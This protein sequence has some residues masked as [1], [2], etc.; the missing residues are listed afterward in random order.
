MLRFQ[1]D[2]NF[3]HFCLLSDGLIVASCIIPV[4]NNGGQAKAIELARSLLPTVSEIEQGQKELRERVEIY[5]SAIKKA[6]KFK[7]ILSLPSREELK[8]EKIAKEISN[9]PII[10]GKEKMPQISFD[11]EARS[12]F[13]ASN[14]AYNKEYEGKVKALIEK[15][16]KNSEVVQVWGEKTEEMEFDKDTENR[17]EEI[18]PDLPKEIKIAEITRNHG[19]PEFKDYFLLYEGKEKEWVFAYTSPKDKT[20]YLSKP[21]LSKLLTLSYQRKIPRAPSFFKMLIQDEALQADSQYPPL[22]L[23]KNDQAFI[24]YLRALLLKERVVHSQDKV[25]VK[26]YFA[27]RYVFYIA[28]RLVE[29]RKGSIRKYEK[30]EVIIKGGRPFVRK[31]HLYLILDGE[32]EIKFDGKSIL[33]KEGDLFRTVAFLRGVERMGNA[34]VTA[35]KKLT[36]A[37]VNKRQF[38]EKLPGDFHRLV[39]RIAKE[40]DYEYSLDAERTD[41]LRRDWVDGIKN[42]IE[43][44]KSLEEVIEKL[45]RL[46]WKEPIENVRQYLNR[47]REYAQKRDVY[48][49]IKHSQQ[50]NED[51]RMIW[52]V[53]PGRGKKGELGVK[54]ANDIGYCINSNAVIP[55]WQEILRILLAEENLL[56]HGKGVWVY[57]NYKSVLIL[58]K[59]RKSLEHELER[60][61]KKLIK[62][63]D[64]FLKGKS[65]L[66]KLKHHFGLNAKFNA[67]IDKGIN[68]KFVITYGVSE[69]FR[70]RE[71]KTLRLASQAQKAAYMAR[72]GDAGGLFFNQTE[73]QK[74]MEEA[75]RL[76]QD[77]EGVKIGGIEVLTTISNNSYEY[78]IVN[79][80]M[81]DFIEKAMKEGVEPKVEIDIDKAVKEGLSLGVFK[82]QSAKAL[83]E[84]FH[85]F[86]VIRYLELV[87]INDFLCEWSACLDLAKEKTEEIEQL[88]GKLERMEQGL[89]ELESSKE[90]F[91]TAHL[92]KITELADEA[93]RVLSGDIKI[94][95]L[96]SSWDFYRKIVD[97]ARRSKLTFIGTDVKGLGAK[98]RNA[99]E[100]L[101]QDVEANRMSWDEVI[102]VEIP[103]LI[104]EFLY[105][106]R[107]KVF[108]LCKERG[109]PD[110]FLL[111]LVGGDEFGLAVP[112][113]Y[114]DKEFLLRIREILGAR[115]AIS[116]STLYEERKEDQ[117]IP[118]IPVCLA[119]VDISEVGQVFA[120]EQES[121]K[122]EA[123]VV[124][125]SLKGWV[126]LETAGSSSELL[127]VLKSI[128]DESPAIDVG[129]LAGSPLAAPH[130]HLHITTM[131]PVLEEAEDR[132]LQW[133]DIEEYL[134]F[135]GLELDLTTGEACI[136]GEIKDSVG[137]EG[138]DGIIFK[139]IMERAVERLNSLEDEISGNKAKISAWEKLLG[140]KVDFVSHL[141]DEIFLGDDN[142]QASISIIAASLKGGLPLPALSARYAYVDGADQLQIKLIL[143]VELVKKAI[144]DYKRLSIKIKK[145]EAEIE[146]LQEELRKL[147]A[148]QKGKGFKYHG[149]LLDRERKTAIRERENRVSS[150]RNS[151]ESHILRQKAIVEMFF[152]RIFHELGEKNKKPQ[153]D[154]E[155]KRYEKA[156]EKERNQ[157]KYD[158]ILYKLGHPHKDIE[159]YLKW[160]DSHPGK[161][162]Y[163]FAFLESLGRILEAKK[164]HSRNIA[165]KIDSLIDLY[166]KD[167]F[168]TQD[169]FAQS[170]IAAMGMKKELHLLKKGIKPE[171]LKIIMELFEKKPEL[172]NRLKDEINTPKFKEKLSPA[173]LE[174]LNLALGSYPTMSSNQLQKLVGQSKRIFLALL[175]K[176]LDL[177]LEGLGELKEA[178]KGRVRVIYIPGHS[179]KEDFE[180]IKELLEEERRL[181]E[182]KK[183][184]FIAVIETTGLAIESIIKAY[185][186]LKKMDFN[187]KRYEEIFIKRFK[188]ADRIHKGLYRSFE[189]G[190][191]HYG[192]DISESGHFGF[193]DELFTYLAENKIKTIPEDAGYQ[194]WL[195]S[196]G[197]ENL[198]GLLLQ[199]F[200]QADLAFKEQ[201]P[202]AYHKLLRAYVDLRVISNTSRDA[203]IANQIENLMVKYPGVHIVIVLG[204]GHLKMH[205]RLRGAFYEIEHEMP[206]FELSDLSP[207]DEV[208]IREIINK[209]LDKKEERG[210]LFRVFPAH[211]FY[212]KISEVE[213]E[214]YLAIKIARKIA[215]R[216]E[217]KEIC[218]LLKKIRQERE[219]FYRWMIE[220]GRIKEEE[221]HYF[222]PQLSKKEKGIKVEQNKKVS[223]SIKAKL[224]PGAEDAIGL[225]IDVDKVRNWRKY[226]G[227]KPD[228]EEL[229]KLPGIIGQL[230][231]ALEILKEKKALLAP[232]KEENTDKVSHKTEKIS[233]HGDE[234]GRVKSSSAISAPGLFSFLLV[235]D[236]S[237]AVDILRKWLELDI[238]NV[239][240]T[241]AGSGEEALKKFSEREGYDEEGK[242]IARKLSVL[243]IDKLDINEI[244]SQAKKLLSIS[245]PIRNQAIADKYN[246]IERLISEIVDGCCPKKQKGI[247]GKLCD[248]LAEDLCSLSHNRIDYRITLGNVLPYLNPQREPRDIGYFQQILERKSFEVKRSEIC[249]FLNDELLIRINSDSKEKWTTLLWILNMPSVMRMLR[250]RRIIPD[251]DKLQDSYEVLLRCA[252]EYDKR[253]EVKFMTY[254]L[255]SIKHNII[256]PGLFEQECMEIE[257][258][259][260]EESLGLARVLPAHEEEGYEIKKTVNE[261]L[262]QWWQK[263]KPGVRIILGRENISCFEI[264]T[265]KEVFKEINHLRGRD[266]R[267]IWNKI[268]RE[269]PSLG[270]YYASR[271]DF[272]E[273]LYF[274]FIAFSVLREDKTFV[275]IGDKLDISR[276]MTRNYFS[277][278]SLLIESKLRGIKPYVIVEMREKLKKAT[279]TL[280]IRPSWEAY[281]FEE[282]N[283]KSLLLQRYKEA[284]KRLIEGGEAIFPQ[285]KLRI[286]VYKQGAW[287]KEVRN[288]F[289]KIKSIYL[290]LPYCTYFMRFIGA[291]NTNGKKAIIAEFRPQG[292]RYPEYKLE[293]KIIWLSGNGGKF[294]RGGSIS[295]DGN[296]GGGVFYVNGRKDRPVEFKLA[297][298]GSPA[299]THQEVSTQ[300]I[301]AHTV[302]SSFVGDVS[303]PAASSPING[304][305]V[306]T[307]NPEKYR[308]EILKKQ[309]KRIFNAAVSIKGAAVTLEAMDNP[310]QTYYFGRRPSRMKGIT[311]V[312]EI[313]ENKIG[314]NL[315]IESS[316]RDKGYGR[317][318][319]AELRRRYPGKIIRLYTFCDDGSQI[320]AARMLEQK[321]IDEI[322]VRGDNYFCAYVDVP[323]IHPPVYIC[324][325]TIISTGVSIAEGVWISPNTIDSF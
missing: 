76:R 105:E 288:I 163:Y 187:S 319:A 55:K 264:K 101:V 116:T 291:V 178:K 69:C 181:A 38:D 22:S 236:N 261:L 34:T 292:R 91:N 254:Y 63:M 188:R 35:K 201:E 256:F 73:Y 237:D 31:K 162:G 137:K 104:E 207:E 278:I 56:G 152:E 11:L 65:C 154:T 308:H 252:S 13:L 95:Q 170:N 316:F 160:T 67:L 215:D 192:L 1:V 284:V 126:N 195:E 249:N 7:Y 8:Q 227:N 28:S 53:V 107:K 317:K 245:S 297:Q 50:D 233:R 58:V 263:V 20:I 303:S 134:E 17:L 298:S 21:A 127:E 218:D 43:E 193:L 33:L 109:I 197:A 305:D 81:I 210:I 78:K 99:L 176:Y 156:W 150:L 275:Q 219:S 70:Q 269:Y 110:E 276:Q 196:Y 149:E 165:Q 289:D 30:G 115:V 260:S 255:A 125:N 138:K 274:L 140:L 19:P 155:G 311:E 48:G 89:D 120:K 231:K 307:F 323:W 322:E 132:T 60:V 241:T 40:R 281:L 108:D 37:T 242:N 51:C 117:L 240:I 54:N 75:G 313:L 42:Q 10:L 175:W 82:K 94:P 39:Y 171:E 16:K 139:E 279:E 271:K 185:P 96:N 124:E 304:V 177:P 200:T 186:E 111:F 300:R 71:E 310:L 27:R 212:S 2:S 199:S 86:R 121:S 226:H 145:E 5:Y 26:H 88:L 136:K 251:E 184:K 46:R 18:F 166:L 41:Y 280:Q 97:L 129:G 247:I 174:T 102:N 204:L 216:L 12:S 320:F 306:C 25:R 131:G 287:V 130:L 57:E 123:A 262:S 23:E 318:A 190:D 224:L 324:K 253:E 66:G 194:Q 114:V 9:S 159:N 141:V 52:W 294:S 198:F 189:Q 64:K 100:M 112:S 32:V 179:S 72:L 106:S 146:E 299:F 239:E 277:E 164:E 47:I 191:R 144:E 169:V 248:L 62:E 270:N 3:T 113:E 128:E 211:Y 142:I 161:S 59:D 79:K 301:K 208:I 230:E 122:D 209:P 205:E 321:L 49:R 153:A 172:L 266:R 98:N 314:L 135:S 267:L 68:L 221:R 272:I 302:N 183:K 259:P 258:K 85:I 182:S 257:E 36:L 225:G 118:V 45:R 265:I 283:K 203:K 168:Y 77:L 268:K 222:E 229:I 202:A 15:S 80:E 87:N 74:A 14:R 6:V 250:K 244:I 309:R 206:C 213:P 103:R 24:R 217:E 158:L 44:A 83:E 238:D 296:N 90:T 315:A 84:R 246:I 220:K 295:I 133:D 92:I 273:S 119:L 143:P 235:D 312:D 93:E 234:Q 285:E 157:I 282:S 223:S 147:R 29:N 325:N 167:H 151:V 148:F 293:Y 180:N 214:T 173:D 4:K 286:N 228:I 290:D 232:E 243:F 61:R